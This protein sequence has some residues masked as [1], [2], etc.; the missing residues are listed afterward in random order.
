MPIAA[1]RSRQVTFFFYIIL[2]SWR[3]EEGAREVG[4][5]WRRRKEVAFGC[6][7]GEGDKQD[8]EVGDVNCQRVQERKSQTIPIPIGCLF[9]I[10]YNST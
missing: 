5:W 2:K 3:R 10:K 9:L 4:G 1:Y 8:P 7:G 6:R